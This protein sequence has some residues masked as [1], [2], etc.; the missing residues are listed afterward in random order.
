MEVDLKNILRENT[1][2]ELTIK[3]GSFLKQEGLL[4]GVILLNAEIRNYG[5]AK[6][7]IEA[8]ELLAADAYLSNT[9]VK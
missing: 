5:V 7:T 8:W 9:R 2:H 6:E 4:K 1:F 3:V